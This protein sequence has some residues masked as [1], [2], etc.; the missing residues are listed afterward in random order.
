MTQVGVLCNVD[1]DGDPREQLSP[2]VINRAFLIG[3]LLA[4]DDIRLFL[5]CPKDVAATG[6]VPGFLLD[7]EQLIAQRRTVPHVNAN[8][9][10]RTRQLLRHGMGYQPFKRWMRERGNE[11]YVPYEFSELVSNKQKA[12]EA[13]R[14]L[15]ESLHPHT[16]D[17]AGSPAQIEDFLARS[18]SVFIKPRAGHKGNGVFVLRRSDSRYALDYYDSKARRSF[19]HLSLAAILGLLDAAASGER[20]VIQEGVE[21]LRYQDSVFD[22]RVVMIHDG[23]GW[24]SLFESRLSPPGSQLSN[25]YQGGTIRITRELLAATVG[26]PEGRRVEDRLREVSGAL[27]RHFESRFPDALCEIGFDFVIDQDRT[28]RLVEV[29]AK[30]GI[31]GIGSEQKLFDWTAEEQALHEQ[32]TIPHMKHL[33]G[34][35]RHKA[36]TA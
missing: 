33:A 1:T 35:L 12:Y 13:V 36:G 7:E 27:A 24:H 28:P 2:S 4:E 20:Y 10:Y 21:C 31:S 30:P 8:W 22:V 9:S 18:T 17:F 3:R 25:V 23:Q 11:V 19:P 14:V 16:E 5:Y 29:N 6:E 32:W 26:E 34:F 15:D